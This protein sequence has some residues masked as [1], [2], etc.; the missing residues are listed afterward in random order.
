[1]LISRKFTKLTPISG[2]D[3]GVE[4][5]VS[6]VDFI[7]LTRSESSRKCP[8]HFEHYM[9][10]LAIWHFTE[11]HQGFMKKLLMTANT[12]KLQID[13]FLKQFVRLLD[14]LT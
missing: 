4:S 13:R 2:V 11:S 14:C 9:E 3:S 5:G 6:R 7:R 1:M 8:T 10:G 12:N